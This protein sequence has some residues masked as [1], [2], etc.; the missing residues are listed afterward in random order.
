MNFLR[1]EN[2]FPLENQ[3]K[4]ILFVL[5]LNKI[6]VKFEG[7]IEFFAKFRDFDARHHENLRKFPAPAGGQGAAATRTPTK[8]TTRKRIS[9]RK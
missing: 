1:A 6:Y 3:T 7:K 2:I 9:I 4:F 5:N 8:L